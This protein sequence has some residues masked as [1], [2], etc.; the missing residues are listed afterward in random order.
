MEE[1]SNLGLGLSSGPTA[2]RFVL[3]ETY[4]ETTGTLL[5]LVQSRRVAGT[6]TEDET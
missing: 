5:P 1:S 2:V 3:V 4:L 6:R